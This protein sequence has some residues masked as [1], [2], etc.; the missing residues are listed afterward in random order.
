MSGASGLVP[1]EVR[2]HAFERF[3][4]PLRGAWVTVRERP[5]LR[6]CTGADGRVHLLAA[7]GE[8]LTAAL[9][10]PRGQPVQTATVRVPA[11]GLVGDRAI[12]L[13]VPL[14]LTFRVLQRLL[15]RPLAG[16]HH[17][18]TTITAAG[19]T[20]AD[21][22]QGEADAK[23][24][25]IRHDGDECGEPPIYLGALPVV[26]KT[27][28]G[29]ALLAA[30]GLRA[31]RVCSSVDGGVLVANLPRGRYTLTASKPGLRFSAAELVIDADSPALINV[32][33][34]QAPRVLA[35]CAGGRS[36]GL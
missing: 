3:G 34:P 20:L 4:R 8:P 18:A 19:K 6:L 1:V 30:L 14:A 35:R 16:R 28:F 24:V 29:G 32:S 31:P 26:H 27:D 22:P 15:V 11:E 7:V 25:L 36:G 33:P 2:A 23:L 9:E 17:L 13:Q 12:T 5:G 21:S 10:H